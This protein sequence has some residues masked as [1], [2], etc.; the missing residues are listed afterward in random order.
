VLT[1]SQEGAGREPDTDPT[2]LRK[3]ETQGMGV[4]GT[5]QGIHALY[6]KTPQKVSA[7]KER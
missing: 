3:R 7:R 5:T 1:R 4:E 2:G 6:G